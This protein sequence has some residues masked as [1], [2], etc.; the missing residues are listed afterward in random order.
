MT[1]TRQTK[2]DRRFL[3]LAE[4]V[5]QWSLDPSTQVGA[6]IVDHQQRVISLGYN[7]FP[8]GINDTP[9][10]LNT[11]DLKMRIVLHAEHNALIFAERSVVDFT[12]ITWP[13]MPCSTCAAM[14]IQAGIKR[15]VSLQSNNIRWV[16]SFALSLELFRE[17][18]V[19]V[20][21]YQ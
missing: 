21:L 10:R 13:F 2:W 15:I 5:S 16:E 6:V 18:G 4:L 9:E 17:A 20:E 1:E 8:R 14:I 12:I 3:K 11:R 19:D 7:G